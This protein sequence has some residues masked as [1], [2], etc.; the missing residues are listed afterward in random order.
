MDVAA[1]EQ[2]NKRGHGPGFPKGTSGNPHGRASIRMRAVE[3]F[4]VMAPDFAGMSAVDEV[5]LRQAC[6]LIARSER[7]HRAKDIDA[8]I[9]QSGEARRLLATL[10]RHAPAPRDEPILSEVLR[11]RYAS[12]RPVDE[13]EPDTASDTTGESAPAYEPAEA[14]EGPS[15]GNM[16]DYEREAE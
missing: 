2:L 1:P 16:N 7:V 15:G 13:P 3:L 12:A 8:S 11:A 5:L 10:R 9:R 14:A 6:M 4:N